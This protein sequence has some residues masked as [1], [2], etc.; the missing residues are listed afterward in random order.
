MSEKFVYTLDHLNTICEQ[1]T[2]AE[3]L[4]AHTH[5]VRTGIFRVKILRLDFCI[6]VNDDFIF[7]ET[8]TTKKS[9]FILSN[10]RG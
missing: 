4:Y 6:A 2:P 5:M 9:E 1:H 3:N 10:E 7:N 8:S